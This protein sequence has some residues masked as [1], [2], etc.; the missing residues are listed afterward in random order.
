MGILVIPL[1]Q[2]GHS[3]SLRCTFSRNWNGSL[4][5]YQVAL[6]P[7]DISAPWDPHAQSEAQEWQIQ[8]V[9]RKKRYSMHFRVARWKY[10]L[11]VN[12]LKKKQGEASNV[13]SN[14]IHFVSGTNLLLMSTVEYFTNLN[15]IMESYIGL[16][17]KRS[18]TISHLI[19]T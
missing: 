17:T 18:W 10:R 6:L 19:D 2:D 1:S 14:I 4:V 12:C 15:E 9:A 7:L 3:Y 16:M 13:Q 5:I 11:S 8:M